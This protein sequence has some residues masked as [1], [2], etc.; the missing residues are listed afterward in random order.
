MTKFN[1]LLADIF[2]ENKETKKYYNLIVKHSDLAKEVIHRNI[3]I[4]IIHSRITI[5][6]FYKLYYIK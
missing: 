6:R 3:K 1:K 4:K 5:E 2:I